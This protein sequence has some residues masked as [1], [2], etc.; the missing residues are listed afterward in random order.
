MKK[1]HN[2]LTIVLLLIVQVVFAQILP[3]NAPILTNI[4]DS[5]YETY[6]QKGGTPI[7]RIPFSEMQKGF[8]PRINTI[9]LSSIPPAS[10]NPIALRNRF[11]ST[12]I[13]DKYFIDVFG[14]AMKMG[15][16]LTY[17]GGAGINI[18]NL[19]VISAAD[20][21][22]NNEIQSL[23]LAGNE[24]SL[25]KGGGTVQLPTPVSQNISNSDL[26][27][28]GTYTMFGETNGLTFDDFENF[29]IIGGGIFN[30]KTSGN[31]QIS[32]SQSVQMAS[33]SGNVNI[34][35]QDVSLVAAEDANIFGENIRLANGTDN[36]GL[37]VRVQDAGGKLE[38]VNPPTGQNIATNDLTSTGSHTLDLGSHNLT[39]LGNKTQ[40]NV[41]FDAQVNC[42][43]DVSIGGGLLSNNQTNLNGFTNI[44]GYNTILGNTTIY[45]PNSFN[46]TT[47]D[48]TG[49]GKLKII[50]GTDH[51][52]QYLKILNNTG[53]VAFSTLPTGGITNLVGG[54]GI[55]IT[56]SNVV[57]L[58]AAAVPSFPNLDTKRHFSYTA[59]GGLV[60]KKAGNIFG[61][62][63]SFEGQDDG[64]GENTAITFR[65][66]DQ[67]DLNP[68]T[69]AIYA[70]NG[71]GLSLN[72]AKNLYL[73]ASQSVQITGSAGVNL[74]T[75][76]GYGILANSNANSTALNRM[77]VGRVGAGTSPFIQF[78]DVNMSFANLPVPTAG[79][80]HV[81]TSDSNGGLVA[82]K[83]IASIMPAASTFNMTTAGNMLTSIHNGTQIDVPM[84]N[85]NVIQLT[86]PNSLKSVVNGVP[87][88]SVDMVNSV[89][90][91]VTAGSLVT[92]VN[93]VAS[94]PIPVASANHSYSFTP[95]KW[96]ETMSGISSPIIVLPINSDIAGKTTIKLIA[97]H[98][99]LTC[100][101]GVFQVW[102]NCNANS[103][104]PSGGG[105][106]AGS[107][108]TKAAC[109]FVDFQ[110]EVITLNVAAPLQAG[111]QI[112]LIYQS[113]NPTYPSGF[114]ATIHVY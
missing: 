26:L 39:F 93:G 100:N 71:G 29:S 112:R 92:T 4:S 90:N 82:V 47:L 21:N 32:G 89:S 24:L 53:E 1:I 98:D 104:L 108:T 48:Q 17:S 72:S 19:G 63:L 18:T 94:A 76:N 105:I 13:G 55:E 109:N 40:D 77:R 113:V 67:N 110:E 45:A 34:N 25:S 84:V 27:F 5:N 97:G 106:Q 59:G 23:S 91:V 86:A 75:S 81:L 83:S 36:T 78:G 49:G 8:A 111:K 73:N 114:F 20:D 57:N 102:Y 46:T 52:G 88:N 54:Q 70:T 79:N 9:A 103:S 30:F 107:I 28:N 7:K 10:G 85:S 44:N 96:G 31:F 33:S 74:G 38:F 50:D 41:T 58:G 15:S 99:P 3:H 95:F 80:T 51:T 56:G 87:S 64:N 60:F 43:D 37:Y 62:P 22:P 12:P 14:V 6:T 61:E 69:H 16:S 101:T 2:I 42:T 66:T 35:G 68:V 65:M 11:V